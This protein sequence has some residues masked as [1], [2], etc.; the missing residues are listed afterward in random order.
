MSVSI[1]TLYCAGDGGLQTPIEPTGQGYLR[2]RPGQRRLLHLPRMRV[3]RAPEEQVNALM[4]VRTH[5]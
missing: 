5:W 3:R 4:C 1:H 2:K